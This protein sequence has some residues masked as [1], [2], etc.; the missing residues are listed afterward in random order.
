MQIKTTSFHLT[1]GNMAII[2][3]K[4][5]VLNKELIHTTCKNVH[6]S[7]TIK[8]SMAV[9]QK[10]KTKNRITIRSSDIPSWAY[11]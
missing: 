9:P 5:D 11:I 1:P 4:N 10:T 8:I 3:N 6:N 7:T 2:N